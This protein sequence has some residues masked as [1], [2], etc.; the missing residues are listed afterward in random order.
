MYQEIGETSRAIMEDDER[1]ID[2]IL[3]ENKD[4]KE[5]YWIVLFVKPMKGVTI[6]GKLTLIKVIKAYF[7][8]PVPQVGMVM[9]EVS[10]AAGK[11]KWEVNMPDRPFGFE[12][13]GLEQDGFQA[14]ETSIPA[15]YVYN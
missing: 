3:C 13:V 10:N 9:G 6:G 8:R 15:A 14:Y 1:Q 4:R 11:I 5:P 12:A 7:S 2:K